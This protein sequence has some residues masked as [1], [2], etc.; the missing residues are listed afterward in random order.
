MKVRS[1]KQQERRRN[2]LSNKQFRG[3]FGGS[4]RLKKKPKYLKRAAAAPR[5]AA[6]LQRREKQQNKMMSQT[7]PQ[8]RQLALDTTAAAALFAAVWYPARSEIG[9]MHGLL[10]RLLALWGPAACWALA[11]VAEVQPTQPT[12]AATGVQARRIG[13][14]LAD[15][16]RRGGTSVL[17]PAALAGLLS[18]HLFVCWIGWITKPAVCLAVL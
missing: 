15:D 16:A 8:A 7:D 5:P 4:A 6:F 11:V 13:C 12:A 3:N 1:S 18:D 14:L 9:S 17:L 2:P 10:L